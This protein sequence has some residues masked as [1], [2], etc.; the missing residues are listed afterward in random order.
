MNKRGGKM[1]VDLKEFCMAETLG[2][3]EKSRGDLVTLRMRDPHLFMVY[4]DGHVI[5]ASY[6]QLLGEEAF[7]SALLLDEGVVEITHLSL[8]TRIRPNITYVYDELIQ[9]GSRRVKEFRSMMSQLGSLKV[10]PKVCRQLKV[11]ELCINALHWGIIV[12]AFKGLTLYYLADVLRVSEYDLAK[13]ALDLVNVGAIA[14]SEESHE[15]VVESVL[16]E[17]R[18]I[19]NQRFSEVKK[20]I[21][22]FK[23]GSGTTLLVGQPHG[24]LKQIDFAEQNAKSESA[25]DTKGTPIKT[26]ESKKATLDTKLPHSNG[27]EVTVT[28]LPFGAS[29]G[30]TDTIDDGCLALNAD[31]FQMIQQ[32]LGENPTQAYIVNPEKE[33]IEPLLVRLVPTK[34]VRSAALTVGAFLKLGARNGQTVNVLPL[35]PNSS[36]NKEE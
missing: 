1:L 22:N 24:R 13:A 7:L 31:L 9:E 3:A 8:D 16:V 21:L 23:E 11:K 2:I 20:P 35:T 4:G 5:Y 26:P 32:S 10:V 30:T 25:N 36:N 34:Q 28:V 12:G 33:D 15:P 14:M 29:L 27:I 6:R 18:S 19:E 17:K